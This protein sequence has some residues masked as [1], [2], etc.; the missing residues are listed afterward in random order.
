MAPLPPELRFSL[1]KNTLDS[2]A[3]KTSPIYDAI[4]SGDRKVEGHQEACGE[5]LG[6]LDA[7]RSATDPTRVAEKT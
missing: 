3:L 5:S 7:Y 2:I 6:M 1:T 4:A